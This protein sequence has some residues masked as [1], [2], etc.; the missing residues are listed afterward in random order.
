[1]HGDYAASRG[2][3][4]V[5]AGLH[6]LFVAWAWWILLAPGAAGFLRHLHL[7]PPD[8][9]PIRSWLLA[10][11]ALVYWARVVFGLFVLL[12]RRV[13]WSETAAVGFWMLVIHTTFAVLGATN[14][15]P[16]GIVAAA[17]VVLYLLGSGLNT[18]SEWQR[19]R[20]KADPANRGRLF[21]GGLFRFARHIN[22][23]GDIVLFTGYALIT[24]RAVALAIPAITALSFVFGHAPTLDRYLAGKYGEAY[25]R[26][27]ARTPRLIPWLY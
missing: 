23:F 9:V 25:A 19:H 8:A 27:A 11:A 2:P 14:P 20:W 26:W 15:S 1:V 16:A 4:A 22:Y 21:T 17:G 24:G 12:Q 10:G 7:G 13:A 3:K 5:L 6:L 18:G